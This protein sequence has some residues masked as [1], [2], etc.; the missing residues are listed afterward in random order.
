MSSLQDVFRV[1]TFR[2]STVFSIVHELAESKILLF[3]KS[4]LESTVEQ[5]THFVL[6]RGCPLSEV[7]FCRVCVVLSTC[8]LLGDPL[9][10]C[11]LLVV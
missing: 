8:P 5:K 11:P 3:R 10:E 4:S 1:S 2:G 6:C 9:L 7:I